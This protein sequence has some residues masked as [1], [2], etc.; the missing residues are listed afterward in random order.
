MRNPLHHIDEAKRNLEQ[1]QKQRES[2]PLEHRGMIAAETI[3]DE[4][5]LMRAEI[6]VIRELLAAFAGRPER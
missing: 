6:A 2:F 3:A 5:T 4:L 1:R